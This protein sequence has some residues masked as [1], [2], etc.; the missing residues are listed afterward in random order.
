MVCF[1]NTGNAR[2]VLENLLPFDSLDEFL[3]VHHD[4][5]NTYEIE[6]SCPITCT[7]EIS[8]FQNKPVLDYSL[9]LTYL[10]T[11][12]LAVH[13]I[14]ERRREA[15]RVSPDDIDYAA[16]GDQIFDQRVR[17]LPPTVIDEVLPQPSFPPK[18]TQSENLEV[19]EKAVGVDQVRSDPVLQQKSNSKLDTMKESDKVQVE[20]EKEKVETQDTSTESSKKDDQE[21]MPHTFA[22]NLIVESIKFTNR[23]E[24][25]IWQLSF[26]HPKADT[27]FTIVNLELRHIQDQTVEFSDLELQLYFSAPT[28]EVESIVKSD[29]ALFNVSGPRGSRGKAELNNQTLLAA[30]KD[31]KPGIVMLE[32]QNG[33]KMGMATVSVYLADMGINHNSQIKKSMILEPISTKAYI[34][35]GLTYKFVEDLER[36]KKE[37]E[38]NFMVE[39]GLHC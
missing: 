12:K 28:D 3:R 34:D 36:W 26:Y 33:E 16:A 20:T 35:E 5:D 17:E 21:E 8:L 24:N 32:N 15:E 11:K 2:L 38:E 7:S 19:I 10:S 4:N 39:V 30:K 6:T 31:S 25:G 18:S 14:L 29:N 9:S 1:I 37:Q 22:Y 13:E 23:V 27:P